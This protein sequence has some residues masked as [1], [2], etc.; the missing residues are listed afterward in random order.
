[1]VT[2][3][4][5]G[6][7]TFIGTSLHAAYDVPLVVATSALTAY[8]LGST[9]GILVGG[10]LAIAHAAPRSRRGDRAGFRGGC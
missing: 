8:L 9:S 6:I 3:A 10:F 1:M 5:I 4:G 7:Q 2:I